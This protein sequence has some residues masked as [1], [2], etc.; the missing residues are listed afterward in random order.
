MRCVLLQLSLLLPSTLL[1]LLLAVMSLSPQHLHRPGSSRTLARS[2][3]PAALACTKNSAGRAA[4]LAQSVSSRRWTRAK[5][6]QRTY[7]TQHGV[8]RCASSDY[9]VL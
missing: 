8:A 6:A 9:H 5:N 1:V 4:R 7:H 2:E 3:L